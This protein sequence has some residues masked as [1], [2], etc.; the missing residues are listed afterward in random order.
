MCVCVCVWGVCVCVLIFREFFKTRS[1]QNTQNAPNCTILK[2]KFG[3][4]LMPPSPP[5]AY[6][7]N[8]NIIISA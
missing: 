6:A 3:G 2:K 5:I 4:A 8:Y 1:H 7:C